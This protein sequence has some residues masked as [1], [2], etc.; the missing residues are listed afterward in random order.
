MNRAI[1]ATGGTG[2]H[3]FPA[4]AVARALAALRPGVEVL[5][6]GG[7]GP[8]GELARKAGLRFAALPA[9][10]VFGRGVKGALGAVWTVK[11]LFMA[12]RLYREFKPEVVAGFGGYA[13]FCPVAAGKLMGLPTA[14]HEQNSVPGMANKALARIV[15]K[16]FVSYADDAGAFPA[17]KTVR[18]GN[19]VRESIAAMGDT[20][21]VSRDSRNILVL[22]GSQGAKAVNQ[23]VIA[24]LPALIKGGAR[25]MIQTGRAD[26]E[27]AAGEIAALPEKGVD[28]SSDDGRGPRV[29]VEN[30]IEDMAAAYEWADLIIARAGAT[31]LAE[32][33]AAKKP[34][35]LIPFPFATHN[36]QLVNAKVMSDAGAAILVEQTDL[37]WVDLAKTALTLMNDP[38]RLADMAKASGELAEPKAAERIASE[39]I[40]L[41]EGRKG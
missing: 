8:E 14:I 10:G 13:G 29:V 30:F 37:E 27:R 20:P 3:I 36:H 18:T 12:L 19:P 15:D 6:V 24:A 1:I 5:F 25:V 32:V 22:G 28:L 34:A 17:K 39:L 31:T 4:L 16:V 40:A 9:Q 41:A 26:F 11:S 2:G 21:H 38:A 35:I 23:A 7:F 33:T